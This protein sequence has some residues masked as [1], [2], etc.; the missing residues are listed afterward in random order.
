MNSKQARAA[1]GVA[2][3]T[4][5]EYFRVKEDDMPTARIL[6]YCKGLEKVPPALLGPMVEKAI[7][8]RTPRWGDIPTVAEL[9]ADA[10]TCR[11]EI[12][13]AHPWE[14]CASCENQP[15]WVEITSDGIARLTRCGCVRAHRAKLDGL[16]VTKEPLSLPPA[17]DFSHVGEE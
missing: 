1:I 14:S 10:E 2:I 11:R 12:L 8:T 16:G 15:G 4:L 9:L 13:A 17:R 6:I 5:V 3:G 7:A